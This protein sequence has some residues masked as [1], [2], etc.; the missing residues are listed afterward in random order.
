MAR[1]RLIRRRAQVGAVAALGLAITVAS[2]GLASAAASPASPTSVAYVALRGTSPAVP[3]ARLGSYSSAQMSVEVA[4]APQDQTGLNDQ[5]H[6]L[7]T[8]GSP[9]YHR[10]LA[11]GQFDKLYAPTTA[12]QSAVAS[13][14]ASSGLT[15]QPS[16]SPFLVR[17]AGSSQQVSAAF[18]TTLST[19]KASGGSQYFANSTAVQLPSA[20]APGVLGVIG[21]NNDYHLS[22]ATAL[23]PITRE[24]PTSSS[25]CETPYPTEAQLSALATGDTSFPFGYGGGPACSGLTPSQVNSIYGAPTAGSRAKGA[26]VTM[27]V[28]EFTAYQ[29]SDPQTWAKTFYGSGYTMPQIDN[30]LVDGGPL[31]PDCPS[32]DSCPASYNGYIADWLVDLDI[33][34]YLTVS[35]DAAKIVVYNAPNDTTGQTI[36]DE[37]TRIADDDTADVI[38]SAWSAPEDLMSAAYVQSENVIFEQ[39]AAQ[40]QA[41]FE[42]AGDEGPYSLEEYT[43]S[44]ALSVRDPSAQPYVTSVGGTSLENY[45]PG[46]NPNPQ[47]PGGDETVWNTGNLCKDSSAEVGGVTGY[48]WCIQSP[49]LSTYFL[50]S[51]GAG[52]SSMYWGRPFYQTG[53]GVNSLY[54][55]YGNGGTQCQLA[56]EG[57]PCREIPDVSAIADEYTPLATFCT[58]T[59]S[60]PNSECSQ[61]ESGEND[62]GWFGLAGTATSAPLWAGIAADRDSYTGGRSG[63][64]NPLLYGLFNANPGKYFNDITGSGQ[65]VNTNGLLPTTPGYDEAT[66]IGTPKMAA[67]ITASG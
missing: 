62:P 46:T 22:P 35:P 28:V 5:L 33:E 34:R 37:Y 63:F 43:G 41:F 51:A 47:Y 24:K 14:L 32:G 20:L 58:G 45:N 44:T 65:T 60:L 42:S 49:L 10:W 38:S 11:K 8:E 64:F 57:A 56:T 53:Q 59:A 7:Y 21:L 26:G 27:A 30:E 54:T 13:Y 3:D 67:L 39:M 2:G 52:G 4:L 9:N 16:G 31:N 61:L 15:V 40:G 29:E 1:V 25:S 50:G 18:R 12:T 48:A 36:L 19:Y 23:A 17:A 6:S 55:T 66:G